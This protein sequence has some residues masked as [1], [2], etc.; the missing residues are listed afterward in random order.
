VVTLFRC[1]VH[2]DRRGALIQARI[3]LVG[4]TVARAN[5]NPVGP[6]S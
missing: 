4:L 2:L 6:A 3:P 5:P 1:P